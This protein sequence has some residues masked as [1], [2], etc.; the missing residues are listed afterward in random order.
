VMDVR[1]D[2]LPEGR[3]AADIVA[4][5]DRICPYSNAI[6]GNVVVTIAANGEP[7]AVSA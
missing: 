6:R 7:L 2:G 4:E 5:A 1:V 3:S